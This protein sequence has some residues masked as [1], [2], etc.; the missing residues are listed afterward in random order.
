MSLLMQALKKAERAKQNLL[1]NGELLKPSEELDK[2]L[3]IMPMGHAPVR[4]RAPRAAGAGTGAAAAA[5]KAARNPGA[6]GELSLSPMEDNEPPLLN[7]PW[8]EAPH[9]PTL[10]AAGPDAGATAATP[11]PA[12]QPAAGRTPPPRPAAPAAGPKPRGAASAKASKPGVVR[13][14]A[15]DPQAMR[16]AL[17]GGSAVLLLCLFGLLYWRAVSAPG[18]GASLPMVP[19]PPPG[20]TA[21]T[22]PALVLVAPPADASATTNTAAAPAAMAVDSTY[23]APAPSAP[24]AARPATAPAT[25]PP[26]AAAAADTPGVISNAMPDANARG[27]GT[28]APGAGAEYGGRKNLGDAA[29]VAGQRAANA[30]AGMAAAPPDSAT[31]RAPASEPVRP[32]AAARAPEPADGNGDGAGIQVRRSDQSSQVNP[33]LQ[34]AYQAYTSG[35]LAGARQQYGAMLRQDPNNRD[36]LLGLAAVALRD[37][38]A[39]SAASLYLR[40]LELDP[41]DGEAV[42]GLVGLR[43]GDPVQSESR[44]K[45]ILQRSPEAGPALFALGNLYAQQGRWPDAQQTFFRAYTSTPGNADYAFNLAVGLDRLNQPKLAL[46]YYQ[47]ALALASNN[48]GAFDRA[49]A[50]RRLHELNVSLGNVAAAAPAVP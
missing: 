13:S 47:R 39:S 42:A 43:H 1:P 46:G 15:L 7:E 35:D 34:N 5:T 31:L 49:A 25:A 19:M 45:A 38:Q 33:V 29:A 50:R 9:D 2:V 17:L 37:N 8:P 23:P 14:F 22:G 21:A 40:L 41:N 6:G 44:L 12:P 3:T 16:L 11:G 28:A 27:Y 26:P 4:Q 24:P 30:N 48:P 10:A 36:A 18:A 20:A 32:R